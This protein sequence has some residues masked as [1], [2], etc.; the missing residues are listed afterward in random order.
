MASD[1]FK[2]NE[3]CHNQI[4]TLKKDI[5]R[6][7]D[8]P[9]FKYFN[10]WNSLI[11]GYILGDVYSFNCP[12]IFLEIQLGKPTNLG[13]G[14]TSYPE[15]ILRFH[16]ISNLLDSGNGNMEQNEE[17][18][19]LR[20]LIVELFNGSG[21]ISRCS[22]L[23]IEED[24]MDYQHKNIYKYI[25]SFKTNFIDTKG[26]NLCKATYGYLV[27]PTLNLNIFKSWFSQSTYI[28]GKTIVYRGKIY[29]C[30][31][32]NSDVLFNLDNWDLVSDWFKGNTYLVDS[33][34][35]YNSDVYKCLV[36]NSDSTFN[37]TNWI[38]SNI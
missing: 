15:C 1:I 24:V 37:P 25:V 16:I 9:I 34:V 3:D 11:D 7:K 26:S 27:N 35:A 8:L 2:I 22:S 29:I 14:Y 5:G 23:M 19:D 17:V 28:V 18:F 13:R 10:I 33:Y 31:V 30:K 6:I 36:E 21:K 20:D 32:E 12:A 4:K 38:K